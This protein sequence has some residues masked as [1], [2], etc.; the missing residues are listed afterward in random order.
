[1]GDPRK[2]SRRNRKKS[3]TLVLP[4]PFLVPPA[5][6]G[7]DYVPPPPPTLEEIRNSLRV[8]DAPPTKLVRTLMRNGEI[9]DKAVKM[10][11]LL[12]L[13]PKKREALARWIHAVLRDRLCHLPRSKGGRPP[14][15]E[16]DQMIVRLYNQMKRDKKKPIWWNVA[17]EIKRIYSLDKD[18]PSLMKTCQTA[19]R[20]AKAKGL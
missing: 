5:A 12:E 16:R 4:E 8:A 7:T 10:A 3:T 15:S 6:P 9:A 19:H 11:A 1:M 14:E 18:L 13:D 17:K 2:S 20:R